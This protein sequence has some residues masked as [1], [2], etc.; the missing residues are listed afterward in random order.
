MNPIVKKKKNGKW[1]TCIDYKDL[2]KAC[3]KEN[4]PLP[5]IDMLVYAM[6]NHEMMKLLD[7]FSRYNQIK[8]DLANEEK[9]SFIIEKALIVTR[10]I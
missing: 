4:F 6:E 2:N 1:K 5:K 3:P 7:A 8:M 10:F 9:T